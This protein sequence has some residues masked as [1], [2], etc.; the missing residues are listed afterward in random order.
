MPLNYPDILQHNNSVYPIVDSNNILGS[1]F[2]TGSDTEQYGISEYKRKLG[3]IVYFS[4]SQDFKYYK[5][6][7]TSSGDW[8]TAANWEVLGG[9]SVNTGSLLLTASVASNIITF[10]KGNGD[11]F[12]ITVD[13]GSGALAAANFTAS[14]NNESTWT[15]N[16]NLDYKY[17]LVQIFDSSDNQIIPEEITLVNNNTAQATFN[18]GVSGKAVVTVGGTTLNTTLPAG[19][20]TQIQYNNGG[21]FGASSNFTFNG[22]TNLYTLKS[23]SGGRTS[24]SNSSQYHNNSEVL[25]INEL[26]TA[27]ISGSTTGYQFGDKFNTGAWSL[28]TVSAGDIV[29]LSGSN[30]TWYRVVQSNPSLA[31]RLLGI[32]DGSFIITECYTTVTTTSVSTPNPQIDGTLEPG[33]P[34]YLKDSATSSPWLSTTRPTTPGGV[35][36]IV[37]HLMYQRSTDANYWLMHFRPDHTWVQLV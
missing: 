11:T 6:G 1:V 3:M 35:V 23:I 37:G 2:V 4:S 24:F 15:I 29:F 18:S 31:S 36:R 16:H 10:T 22:S 25:Q 33:A 5:G 8:G 7:T 19:S 27:W 9:N 28:G 20:N 21:A 34:V 14:F 30:S 12:P 32:Y 26:N 13:T 17:V